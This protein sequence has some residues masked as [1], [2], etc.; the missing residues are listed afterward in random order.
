[1]SQKY[2]QD[3]EAKIHTLTEMMTELM[4][5]IKEIKQDQITY[6]HKLMEIK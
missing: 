3:K 2:K 4:N 5:N 6:Q 1:M